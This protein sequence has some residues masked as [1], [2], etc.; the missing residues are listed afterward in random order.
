MPGAVVGHI[1]PSGIPGPKRRIRAMA[2]MGAVGMGD[3]VSLPVPSL[4]FVFLFS[5]VRIV[6]SNQFLCVGDPRNAV[7]CC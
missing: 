2:L 7:M 5:V 1:T 4:I 6:S 3:A